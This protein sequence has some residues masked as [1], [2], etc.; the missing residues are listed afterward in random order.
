VYVL[1]DKPES[2]E[3]WNQ[4]LNN[5]QM[6]QNSRIDNVSNLIEGSRVNERSKL[7]EGNNSSL[8]FQ[9]NKSLSK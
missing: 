4:M 1:K 7:E 8:M 5:S 2:L 9:A 3:L 6:I